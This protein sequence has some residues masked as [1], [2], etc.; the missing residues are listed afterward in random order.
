MEKIIHFTIPSNPNDQQLRA[1]DIAKKLH[2]EWAVRVWKD[3]VFDESF[4]LYHYY[5]KANSGAQLADLIRLD[6]VYKYGGIYL[7]SDIELIKPL[8][9]IV[10]LDSFFCS[11][12]GV[13]LTNAAFGAKKE[14]T[15]IR[16]IID[17]LVSNEPDWNEKPNITTGP[18]LF[19]RL[20]KW[21]SEA[22]ILP[23]D[24]FYPY[25]WNEAETLANPTTI[26]V[27]RWAGSWLDQ[28]T[29]N[30]KKK[31]VARQKNSKINI[32]VFE[33]ISRK[34]RRILRRTGERLLSFVKVRIASTQ[35]YSTGS[36]LI[37]KTNRGLF[38]SLPGED[39][40]ITPEIAINGTY[41]E[42]ELKFLERNLKGGDFFIDVGCNVGVFSLLAGRLVGPFGRVFSYD[43]NNDVL[44]HLKKSLVMNWMHDRVEVKNNAIGEKKGRLILEYS[45][46][47]LGG[48]S[49]NLDQD[50]VFHKSTEFLGKI[51]KTEVDVVT[52]DSEFPLGLEIKILKID[53]EGHEFSVLAGAA[54]LIKKR[55]IKFILLEL[56]EEVA[57]SLHG[58]NIKKVNEIIKSG[59]SLN[60]VS[61]DGTLVR[62]DGIDKIERHGR[63]IVLQR[64]DLNE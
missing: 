26:G 20:L 35:V 34:L 42:K 44:F 47:C 58:E 15:L 32:S 50:S 64:I 52:L 18:K 8:D 13:N 11:E 37:S 3:P 33:C 21:K 41:E 19:S 1:I 48:A 46:L 45:S 22:V 51:R 16:S 62:V 60:V 9:E 56:L 17:E 25:N 12:D 53:V 2:P 43:A 59:Y 54:E 39:L 30:K 63:N 10:G 57:S 55:A 36:D 14:S 40:S 24:T 49:H 31:V 29:I 23:R 4:L 5:P 27:H 61:S 38:M 7:D 6:V 28:K